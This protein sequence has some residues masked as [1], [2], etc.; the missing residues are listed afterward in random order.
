M[1][2]EATNMTACDF[3]MRPIQWW[4][5]KWGKSGVARDSNPVSLWASAPKRNLPE[6]DVARRSCPDD[7]K[8]KTKDQVLT[9]A[10]NL[11][12]HTEI[13][14]TDGSDRVICCTRECGHAPPTHA[15][16][17]QSLSLPAERER[18]V[19]SFVC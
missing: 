8:A 14:S 19:R 10:Y 4:C 18:V 17:K 7:D 15:L 6:I 11:C 12:K 13:S 3:A 9:E 16:T 2:E 1:I 5:C